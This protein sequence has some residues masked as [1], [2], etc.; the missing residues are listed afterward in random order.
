MS[1]Q[2]KIQLNVKHQNANCVSAMSLKVKVDSAMMLASIQGIQ[3]K[4]IK[5]NKGKERRGRGRR[6]RRRNRC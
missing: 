4:T 5:E 3:L 6:R 2:Y 1:S